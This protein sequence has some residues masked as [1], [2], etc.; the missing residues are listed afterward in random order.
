[1]THR[2]VN[3]IIGGLIGLL[4]VIAAA[5]V[6]KAQ[7]VRQGMEAICGPAKMMYAKA[8]MERGERRIMSMRAEQGWVS[9]IWVDHDSGS[10][11]VFMTKGDVVCAIAA[12]RNGVEF[13]DHQ[14]SGGEAS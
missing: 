2:A 12:G 14:M 13:G 10:W 4:L 1:M 8:E 5:S 11:S 6:A 3:W 7:V 9:E